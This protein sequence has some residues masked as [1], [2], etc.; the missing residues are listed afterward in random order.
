MPKILVADDNTNIQKMVSLAFEE[1]GIDVVSV[2]NGEAAVR[3]IP[4]MN[5]D[6]VLADI[7]MPV[8]NGYEV[9]EFVKKDERFSHVPVILL[10]GAFDP[11]DEKEARR[12]GADGV[13]KKPFVPPDPLIAMV[14]SALEKNPKVAAEMAKARETPAPEPE[15]M[16]AILEAPAR[17]EV[18]PLPE[19]PE[20]S[21]EEAALVYGFGSGKRGKEN[22]AEQDM[23][24]VSPDADEE[25]EI[26]EDFEAT[27]PPHNWRRSAMDFEVPE[28]TSKSP[29]AL[30]D[31]SPAAMF[32]SEKDVPP[33]HVRKEHRPMVDTEAATRIASVPSFVPPPPP[34]LPAARLSEQL[35]GKAS[36]PSVP[37]LA[38]PPA[39]PI[40]PPNEPHDSFLTATM[41]GTMPAPFSTVAVGPLQ[42][43]PGSISP[44]SPVPDWKAPESEAPAASELQ[45]ATDSSE[46][47]M[48]REIA[49]ITPAIDFGTATSF[50]TQGTHWMDAMTA[51]LKD[52]HSDASESA[53]PAPAITRDLDPPVPASMPTAFAPVPMATETKLAAFSEELAV[54][55][56]PIQAEDEEFFADENEGAADWLPVVS[57]ETKKAPSPMDEPALETSA[58]VP[59]GHLAADPELVAEPDDSGPVSKDPALV[60]PPAVHVTPEPLLVDEESEPASTGYDKHEE[61][62]TP[63]FAFKVPEASAVE[64]VGASASEETDGDRIPTMPPPNREILAEIPFLSPP[65]EFLAPKAEELAPAEHDVDAVVQKVL[66]KL[67]PHLRDLL[68]QGVKPLVENILQ[69]ETAKKSR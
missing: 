48:A 44:V 38:Q 34:P 39:S 16:P 32:P 6:L 61:E 42:S 31:E 40:A 15:P 4:D 41:L 12:V 30:D 3:R 37:A 27:A 50:A 57:A 13:L 29:F 7:F 11:L 9:C 10:V 23:A 19:F 58:P 33:K 43:T 54:T 28:E 20:P 36:A 62:T 68:S 35:S 46:T 64:N 56:E 21:P 67:E 2:G 47:R 8:R 69:N 22:A 26:E 55:P 52:N 60:E 53:D 63:A 14:I 25:E 1:R 18:K 65:A 24:P 45:K 66:E 51:A 59:L 17:A 49:P 5:P